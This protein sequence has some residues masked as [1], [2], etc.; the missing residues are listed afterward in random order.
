MANKYLLTY[1]PIGVEQLG[2]SLVSTIS[3]KLNVYRLSPPLCQFLNLV[4]CNPKQ[5]ISIE[6]TLSGQKIGYCLLTVKSFYLL[7]KYLSS[8]CGIFIKMKSMSIRTT[9]IWQRLEC[10]ASL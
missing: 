9:A 7:N 2:S 6:L 1:L 8:Y 4:L 5:S 3:A 10:S